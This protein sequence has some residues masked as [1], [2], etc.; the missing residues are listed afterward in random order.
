MPRS[1]PA[2][3]RGKKERPAASPR[4]SSPVEGHEPGV[5]LKSGRQP[6]RSQAP[7]SRSCAAAAAAVNQRPPLAGA[8]GTPNL[9][10]DFRYIPLAE[11]KTQDQDMAASKMIQQQQQQEDA[12][13]NCQP[14]R[15]PPAPS[16]LLNRCPAIRSTKAMKTNNKQQRK[17]EAGSCCHKNSHTPLH[18]EAPVPSRIGKFCHGC[19]L[20]CLHSR[21][22]GE[23]A[24]DQPVSRHI[25]PIGA[26][27]VNEKRKKNSRSQVS[28]PFS[29][30]DN[31][32]SPFDKFCY[33]RLAKRKD[34]AQGAAGT[35]QL[36]RPSISLARFPPIGGPGPKVVRKRKQTDSQAQEKHF[37]GK[38][39]KTAPLTAAEKP[40]NRKSVSQQKPK[41]IP[42]PMLTAA[43]KRF[44]MYCRLP[45]DRLVT[46]R[47]TPYNLLQERYA[48]DPWKVIV[49]CMLLN[50]TRGKPIKELVEGFFVRYPDAQTACNADLEG[51]VEYL[52]P[53]GLQLE[54][55]ERI[56]K[57]SSSYLSPDWTYV[58]ELHGVGKYAADA[59][60]I[61]CAGRATEVQPEDHKLVDYWKYVCNIGE[62]YE[63]DESCFAI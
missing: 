12:N 50:R 32:P 55:S 53:T 35:P 24:Q 19:D 59:Y 22:Q 10:E 26:I 40:K 6:P 29:S 28:P 16:Y 8:D 43:E 45:P 63:D 58:T 23:G 5:G 39:R 20:V 3:V 48:P 27:A 57:F 42:A 60:A 51:M 31:T 56:R 62:P 44:D 18:C 36:W 47:R 15:A 30:T 1:P 37:T 46:P 13:P 9:F 52:R 2:T 25:H 38:T 49:I 33:I 17:Q 21:R 61:F 54:K 11:R 41:K 34:Q 7:A 4:P 14:P